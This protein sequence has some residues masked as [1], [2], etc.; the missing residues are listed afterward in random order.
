MA[1]PQVGVNV[2]QIRRCGRRSS[3]TAF[4]TATFFKA[5]IHLCLFDEFRLGQ[6]AQ[7]LPVR[8]AEFPVLVDQRQARIS[9]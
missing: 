1:G 7:D 8:R 5:L 6:L 9:N 3:G 4:R 2:I